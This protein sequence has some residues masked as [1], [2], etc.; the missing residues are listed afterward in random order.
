MFLLKKVELG[1]VTKKTN[2]K[3]SN[4]ECRKRLQ[5]NTMT[6]NSKEWA[7]FSASPTHGGDVGRIEFGS[8]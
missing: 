7:I 5:K 6:S 1:R 3:Q 4:V 8:I 2:K